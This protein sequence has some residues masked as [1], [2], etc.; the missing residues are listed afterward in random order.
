MQ[1]VFVLNA[2]GEPL[3]PCHPARARELLRRGR[4]AVLRHRPFTIILKEAVLEPQ[5]QPLAVKVDPGSKQTGFALVREGPPQARVLWA[6]EVAHRGELV[7]R[8]MEQRRT[9]RRGRRTRHTR[10]RQPRFDNRHRPSTW[11]PPS[12]ES[13]VANVVTWVRRLQKI[14]P[15]TRLAMELVRF[16]TQLMENPEVRGVGYQQG[17]LAGYEVREYLLEKWGRK[18]SYCGKK[19]VPLEV[20]HIIPRARGGSDCVSNLALAC[21]PCNVAKGT[22][23]A[24]E[25]G[26]PNVQAQARRPLKDAAAV[27]TTRWEVWRRLQAFGLPLETATGGRTKF[28]RCQQG[29]EKAHWIDAACVGIAG[30]DV[31]LGPITGLQLKAAGHGRRQMCRTDKYGFPVAHKQRG[32]ATHGFTTG[33]FVRSRKPKGKGAGIRV[34]NVTTRASGCF[35]LH[36]FAGDVFSVNAKHCE[37]LQRAD[38]YR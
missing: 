6:A 38:G 28:N 4:A 10:Y 21:N 37:I 33:D 2:N 18:C 31:V 30:G 17:T 34:G 32:Q 13:R 16:D 19:D 1:Y 9:L 15:V 36:T 23:T 22:Q 12:R 7:K 24:E 20:E 35:D 27:N 3:M 5:T 11:V 14:A 26:H 25:F 29:L 8:R